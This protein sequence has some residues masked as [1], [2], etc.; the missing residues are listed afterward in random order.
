MVG[1]DLDGCFLGPAPG[2]PRRITS[3]KG[4][5]ADEMRFERGATRLRFALLS[6]LE[7][8]NARIADRV[9]VTSRYSAGRAVEAYG[10]DPSRVR[11]VPEGIDLARW[12]APGPGPERD[13]GA[14][15]GPPTVLSVARQYPRKD[16][17]TLV[18]A[19]PRVLEA[20]PTARLRVIGGGPELPSLRRL[21]ARIG[22]AGAVDF[23]G[24]VDDRERIRREYARAHAFALP[25]LQEGF[26][27]VFLEA[28]ASRL[29]VVAA[30]AAAVPEVVPHGEA[31]LLVP[32]GDREAL[33]EALVRLLRDP[34]LRD[35][36]GARGREHVRRFDWPRVARRFLEAAGA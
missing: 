34:G 11:V 24:E 33:A 30:R 5:M 25:S 19:M 31:G 3:L 17:R 20:L 8:R 4:V 9:V 10:L 29:P 15:A 27:I 32:P 2:G 6:R 14:A 22:V 13:G 16:T 26:G 18:G 1:F 21:A 35:R 7:G 36:M 12:P 23:A 28:M